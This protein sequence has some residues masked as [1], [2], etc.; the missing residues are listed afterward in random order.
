MISP[1]PL[2]GG[3]GSTQPDLQ[4]IYGR[5]AVADETTRNPVIVITGLLGTRLVDDA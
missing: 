1:L 3:C 5:A 4:Q 2:L